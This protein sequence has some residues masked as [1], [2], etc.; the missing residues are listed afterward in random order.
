MVQ[1]SYVAMVNMFAASDEAN[2]AGLIDTNLCTK[3]VER[4]EGGLDDAEKK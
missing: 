4:R 3:L 1:A 2:A